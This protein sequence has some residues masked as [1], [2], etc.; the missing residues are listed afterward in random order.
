MTSRQSSE[1]VLMTKRLAPHAPAPS[2]H[3]AVPHASVAFKAAS[4]RPAPMSLSERFGS[5][6]AGNPIPVITD[7]GP[8]KKRRVP[9]PV[10]TE[11]EEHIGLKVKLPCLIVRKKRCMDWHYITV[12]FD[13][14]WI[15]VLVVTNR[16]LLIK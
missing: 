8:V 7:H 16:A 1:D 3:A 6:G 5:A 15:I 14:L 4:K 10:K 12:C 11:P 9:E 2:Y 13:L